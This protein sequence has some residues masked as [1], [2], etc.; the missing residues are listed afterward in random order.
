MESMSYA[1]VPVT[2]GSARPAPLFVQMHPGLTVSGVVEQPPAAGGA[3]GGNVVMLNSLQNPGR[4]TATAQPLGFLH[5]IPLSQTPLSNQRQVEVRQDGTF[6]VQGLTPG[7]Y[8]VVPQIW[9]PQPSSM[10]TVQFGASQANRGVIELTE[11]SSG[12]LRVRMAASPP[13]VSANLAD[14]P[15]GAGGQWL[16]FAL[17]VDEPALPFNQFMT[18]P[19]KSGDTLRMQNASAGKFAFVAV[20][21]TMNGGMQNEQL[22]QLLRAR[23]EPVEIV[24][25][26][27]QT[28][29]PRF[30]TSQEIEKLALAY[31]RGETR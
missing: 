9:S 24:A 6:T 10:E 30:F 13:Q 17:P 16:V 25:G 3:G 15:A 29:S 12:S 2:V 11:G 31:L 27:E 26:Q 20:E 21:M 18:G 19:G 5:L 28:V 4:Q 1:S 23:V 22:N 8:K 14:A 7:R